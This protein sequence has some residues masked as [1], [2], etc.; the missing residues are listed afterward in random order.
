M[1]L[2]LNKSYVVLLLLLLSALMVAEYFYED[3]TELQV[4]RQSATNQFVALP[5]GITRYQIHGKDE[6]PLVVMIHSFNGF[7]EVW[8]PNVESLVAAG[9]RVLVY[10]LWG[11]GLSDR[12]RTQLTLDVFRA[13]LTALLNHVGAEQVY[14]VGSSF[15]CIIAADYALNHVN[16]VNKLVLIGPAGWPTEGNSSLLIG[17]PVIADGLFHYFGESILKPKVEAYFYDSQGHDWALNLWQEYAGYPG[18]Y[19]SALSTLQ[20]APVNDYTSGWSELGALPKPLLFIWGKEDVSFPFS[21]T[22]QIPQLM[23]KAEV[24]GV[25][26]AAHW[27]NI[28]QPVRVNQVLINFLLSEQH[29]GR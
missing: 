29:P 23:P 28:E 15:G 3:L 25:E 4:A 18:F 11:R 7:L 20:N 10:D 6:D 27:V 19:R 22:E 9:Y 16:K 8:N 5:G 13:Q 26:K 21:H 14:L 24:V 12:P 2:K 1:R 17:V